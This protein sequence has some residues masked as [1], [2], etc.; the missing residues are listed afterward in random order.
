MIKEWRK[1]SS[2]DLTKTY[3]GYL[4]LEGF[5]LSQGLQLAYSKI[6]NKSYT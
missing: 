1:N 4:I 3:P 2:A 5:T 6:C